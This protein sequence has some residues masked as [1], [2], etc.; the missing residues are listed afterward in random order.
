MVSHKARAQ[1]ACEAADQ[2]MRGS[3]YPVPE[4]RPGREPW[5]ALGVLGCRAGK[6]HMKKNVAGRFHAPIFPVHDLLTS[7]P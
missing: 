4:L 7:D 1:I 3:G 6:G 2:L 5:H